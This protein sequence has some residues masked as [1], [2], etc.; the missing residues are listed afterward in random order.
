MLLGDEMIQ[1]KDH[2]RIRVVQ[3]PLVDGQFESSLIDALKYS[4][5]LASDFTNYVLKGEGGTMKQ[6]KGSGNPR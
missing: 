6:F 1:A 4:D 5:L 3:D 2:E